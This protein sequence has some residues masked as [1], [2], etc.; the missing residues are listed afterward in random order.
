MTAKTEICKP[1]PLL[2]D[3]PSDDKELGKL[4]YL[5]DRASA[6]ASLQEC[7]RF[8][9]ENRQRCQRLFDQAAR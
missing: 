5:L 3:L 4:A 7:D 6:D 9:Q 1:D 8:T 2:H